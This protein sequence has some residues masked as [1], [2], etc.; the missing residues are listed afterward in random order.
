MV[1]RESVRWRD[2]LAKS[3]SANE[4]RCCPA[5]VQAHISGVSAAG[6]PAAS[7]EIGVGLHACAY[8]Q[9]LMKSLGAA[10]QNSSEPAP[11]SRRRH[12]AARGEGFPGAGARAGICAAR[13][14]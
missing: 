1:H 8:G 10:K 13:P 9:D 12:R 3:A 7:W 4:R 11:S 2:S 6:R 14:M 5:P